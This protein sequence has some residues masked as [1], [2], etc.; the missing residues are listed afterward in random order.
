[1]TQMRLIALLAI[2]YVLDLALG[3]DGQGVALAALSGFAGLSTYDL[4]QNLGHIDLSD[5]LSA[6]L[7][8]DTQFL[9][10]VGVRGEATQIDHYWLEESLAAITVTATEAMDASELALSVVAVPAG[11]QIGALLQDTAIGKAE[12]MQVTAISSL[13]LTVVRGAGDSAPAG[14][15]HADA[16]VYRIIGVPK[17][18][19]DENV[20]D[21]TVART[22]VHNICQIFKKEIFISGTQSAIKMAGVPN[23][24]AHQTARRMLELKRQLG[25]SV[26]NSVKISNAGQGGSDSV[27]RSMN[28]LRNFVRAEA[29]QLVTTSQALDEGVVNALY[30]LIY[31][32]GGEANFALGSAEQLTAFSEMYKDKVRLAPS[33]KA[34]GV[35]VTKFLTDLG[36]ELDLIMDRWALDGDLIL[37]DLS[38]VA[39]VPL[40][41]RAMQSTPLEKRGDAIR[42]MIV[43]EY[44]LEVRNAGECFALHTGLTDR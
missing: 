37:G 43:G 1:M 30:R 6:V 29:T 42:G 36:V 8:A 39:L 20:T 2:A 26:I 18:E 41:G 17:P 14:E 16:A 28:G 13:D 5:E 40:T 7:N 25:I 4:G 44:T 38:R 22:R 23:E 11:L 31:A 9:G 10:R 33:E 34:R 32:Q 3:L 15:T 12:I 35:Y 27:Y 24:V 19:G 21:E